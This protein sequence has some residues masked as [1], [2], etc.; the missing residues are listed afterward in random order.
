[1]PDHE[2]VIAHVV[3]LEDFVRVW[4]ICRLLFW[5]PV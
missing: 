4:V 2:V 3:R 5:V 1:M